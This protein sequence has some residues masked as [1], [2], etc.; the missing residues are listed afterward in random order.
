MRVA[1]N[2]F[3]RIGR[4]AFRLMDSIDDIDI[5]AI[6]DL[7]T[8]DV[9]SYLLK[10]DSCQKQYATKNEISNTNDSIIVS[11]KEIKVYKESDPINLPWKE[12]DVDVVLECTGFFTSYEKSMAHIK[13]GAK[14]VIISAPA[15]DCKTIVYGVNDDILTSEDLIISSASC[16]TN[17]LAPMA[18]YLNELSPIITGVMSTVH[19]YTQDQMLLDGS[20]KKGNLRRGRA[21]ATNIVPT[22]S[23]AGKAIGLVLP[24]LNG[25]LLGG[26]IRVPVIDG[27]LTI[28]DCLVNKNLT[29]DEVNKYMLSKSNESFGYAKDEIVSSDIIGD[30]HGGVFDPSQTKVLNM[31]DGKSFVSISAWYDN[32]YGYTHQ[33][34]RLALK[35]KKLM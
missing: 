26:A 9:L 15:T 1:I 16:T 25:R 3:G 17:C 19:A 6:N 8:P 29:V 28:L 12:L 11:G 24:E 14:K 2:G 21:A 4:M 7:T 10:Y 20:H 27:S 33:M 34:I 18:K 35:L 13:A 32:E 30:T 23:G 22:S 31:L 5:V